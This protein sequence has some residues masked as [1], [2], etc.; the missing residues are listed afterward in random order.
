MAFDIAAIQDKYGVNEEWA[1]GDD[2]Y[3]LKDVNAAGTFYS[4]IWDGGGNDTIVY[5]GERDALIDLR[6]ATLNYEV[7]GG[8]NVSFATGIFG[9]FTIANGVVIENATGGSGNDLLRGNSGVNALSGRAGND[10]FFFGADLTAADLVDGGE[11]TD[12]LVLQGNYPSLALAST[13]LAGIEGI[14]LQSG[15]I[16][17][18]GEDGT[19]SYDYNLTVAEANA[20]AGQQLRVNAQSLKAGEDFTFNGSAETDGGKFLVYAGFGVETLTGGTGN[21]IFFFEA[22]R[23]GTGDRVDGGAGSGRH[24]HAGRDDRVGHADEHRIGLGQ[25][26]LCVGPGGAPIL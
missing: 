11:G 15:T 3:T 17:R 20:S 22:G 16:T 5:E 23:L 24:G 10:T 21:D 4:S 25:R 13:S 12:T 6:A 9:G 7:G 8:G 19:A 14:S 26:P 18:W 1:T 2:T